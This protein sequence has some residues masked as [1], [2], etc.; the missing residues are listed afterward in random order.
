MEMQR[1]MSLLAKEKHDL[2]RDLTETKIEKKEADIKLTHYIEMYEKERFEKE[3]MIFTF[4]QFILG[5]QSTIHT[6]DSPPNYA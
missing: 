6:I 3:Q 1:H 5:Q 4:Q 2:E